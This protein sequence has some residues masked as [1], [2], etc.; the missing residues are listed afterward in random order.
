MATKMTMPQLGESVTEGTISKWLVG[1]GDKVNKYDPIAEVLTDKVSA[2]IPSSFT[3]TITELLVAEDDTV[4]VGTDICAIEEVGAAP[5]ANEPVQ[6]EESVEQKVPHS[7]DNDTS[8]KTRYSPAVMR[9]AQENNIDLNS[10]SGSGRG[11]RIT[12]KDVEA[13]LSLGASQ[14][15][16]RPEKEENKEQEVVDSVSSKRSNTETTLKGDK[17]IAV[18]GVRKAI[19]ANMVKSK[20]EMPH[21]W[22]MVEVDVT[23]LVNLRE[24]KKAEFKEQEGYNLTYL[25][26]FMKACVEALKEFPQMNSQWADDKI[27]RKKEINVSMAAATDDA[28]FVP[29]IHNADELTIKGLAKKTNELAGKVRSGKLSGE[30]MKNGTFTINNTGSFGSI[31]SQPIINAPQAAILSIES[32][33]KRPVIMETEAGD[34]IAVRHMVNLCL[35]LDHRVLDGLICGRFLASIKKRLEHMT[36][37]NTMI[38]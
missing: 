7:T 8:Q 23:N 27:I 21:A 29:V 31:L 32:I 1:P 20:S 4:S 30:D 22:T 14:E 19:A 35:S 3:G 10:I 33:V 2:E 26:F 28:L 24:K 34:V 16:P 37:E 18:S 12:R 5:L 17:E 36:E 38:Y 11:G 6:E 25:P 13:Y 15:I 9:L